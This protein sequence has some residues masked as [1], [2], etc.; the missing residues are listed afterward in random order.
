[1]NSIRNIKTLSLT[2]SSVFPIEAMDVLKRFENEFNELVSVTYDSYWERKVFP[3]DKFSVVLRDTITNA[4]INKKRTFDLTKEDLEQ[5]LALLWLSY[6]K[7]YN[8]KE[9][10][11]ETS[12]KSYIIR[13]SIWGLRD[14]L[15]YEVS[16]ITENFMI[17]ETEVPESEFKIDLAFL[18]HGVEFTLLKDL[19]PY[20]RYIIFLKFKED[21]SILQMSHILQKDRRMVKS[22]FDSIIKRIK[23]SYY[24]EL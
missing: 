3:K 1:M 24:N 4:L 10:K 22:H 9:D 8:S 14:W 19:S 23:E 17:P 5:Q 18:F 7:Q 13:R 12:L 2:G 21:K 6:Y 11:P 16:V 20:E 15:K